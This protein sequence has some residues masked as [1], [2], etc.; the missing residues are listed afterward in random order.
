MRKD[1]SPLARITLTPVGGTPED[2]EKAR[3]M[4]GALKRPTWWRS[5]SRR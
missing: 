2:A 1:S 5:A 4:I 3:E